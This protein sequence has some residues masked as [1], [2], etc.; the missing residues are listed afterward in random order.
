MPTLAGAIRNTI[1]ITQF[2]RGMASKIFNDV[3]VNGSKVVMKNNTAEC[4]LMSPEQ[5]LALMDELNDSRLLATALE[6][7]EKFDSAMLISEE[8]SNRRLGISEEDLN[9]FAEVEL[10]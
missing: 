3:K 6:R 1:S 4:V 10:E 5:Y 7:M 2:N 9:N 8:E